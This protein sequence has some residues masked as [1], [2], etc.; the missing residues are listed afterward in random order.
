M[1]SENLSKGMKTRHEILSAANVLFAEQGYHGTSMRQIA[2]E[3]GITLGGIYN[4]FSGK[5]D[6]FQSLIIE[7]HPIAEVVPKLDIVQG[8]NVPETVHFAAETIQS[9]LEERGDYINL[10]F[11]ELVE[12]QGEHINAI[13]N[14]IFPRAVAIANRLLEGK[15]LRSKNTPAMFM[16]F[17]AL[18]FAFFIINRFISQRLVGK[19]I[20]L[21]L[22]EIVDL[23]LYG[24]MTD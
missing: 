6:I 23:Y 9:T 19:F 18:M 16:S 10:F 2:E 1:D 13:F 24:I 11:A 15:E 7:Y 20:K 3:A 17:L 5:E 21:D 8:S 12:F 4:H 14:E 22:N